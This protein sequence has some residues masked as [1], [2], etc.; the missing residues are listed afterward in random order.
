MTYLDELKPEALA[1]K[2]VL[3]RVDFN[4]PVPKLPFALKPNIVPPDIETFRIK[5]HKHTLDYLVNAGAKVT[6]VSHHDILKS[7]EPIV[8]QLG[9]IL[10]RRLELI[11][12]GKLQAP[13]GQGDLVLLDNIRQDPREEQNDD[14]F[15]AGLA[16]GFDLYV[17][18]AFSVSHRNHATVAAIT[19]FLPAYGGLLLKKEI[20][21]LAQ[22]I[23]TPMAGKVLIIGGAKISTK[24]PVI[25]NFLDKAEKILIGGAIA[26]DFFQAQGIKVGNSIVDD[27][28]TPDFTSPKILLPED[29]LVSADLSGASVAAARQV[30]DIGAEEIIVDLG[31]KSAQKFAEIIADSSIAI[32]NGPLGLAEVEAFAG[33]TKAVA[34]AVA[35]AKHSIIGGGDTI[36]AADKLGLLSKFSFVSTG[37]GAMLEFLAGNKLPGLEALG[38]YRS[39]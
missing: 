16:E 13:G 20:E 28:I 18:D 10:A 33:G 30:A 17:N 32:W 25:K 11:S 1:G 14:G 7:F 23:E 37:G 31:P 29:I 9:D 19:K 27:L 15:A 6:L 8:G 22:A 26:N 5:A 21:N 4:A 35:A 39:T 38:Y 2:K 3:L 34:Q 12:L 36:A 24:E